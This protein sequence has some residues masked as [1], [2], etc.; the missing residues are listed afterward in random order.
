HA[1]DLVPGGASGEGDVYAH[2]RL[3][4]ITVMAS[5]TIDGEWGNGWS[6]TP[7]ISPD[8]TYIVFNS[9]AT[10]MVPG[11]TN[12]YDDVFLRALDVPPL[13]P[14][15]VD[16][17][18]EVDAFDLALLLGNWGPCPEPCTPGDPPTCLADFDHD[19]TVGPFDLAFLLG[20][21]GP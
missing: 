2:D 5:T 14:G 7:S 13:T 8:G 15:D 20:N 16:C 17:D 9:S 18:G 3:T 19:C 1:T 12:G 11:D 10:N 21:W 6:I 4:G